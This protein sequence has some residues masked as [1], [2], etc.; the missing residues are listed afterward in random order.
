MDRPEFSV[1]SSI[2]FA[3]FLIELGYELEGEPEQSN[4]K[5]I[6]RFRMI[7]DDMD[8]RYREY[9]ASPFYQFSCN[10]RMLRKKLVVKK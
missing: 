4:K 2:D 9:V 5:Y 7:Q 6:I 8:K 10:A 1:T 3:S